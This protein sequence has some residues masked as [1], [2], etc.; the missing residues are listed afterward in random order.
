[1]CHEADK[2]YYVPGEDG[3]R[4]RQLPCEAGKYTAVR[5][6]A[7]CKECEAGR[8]TQPES[9]ASE[10]VAAS[11]GHY[12]KDDDRTAATNAH[13]LLTELFATFSHLPASLVLVNV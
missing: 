1:M 4:D 2:G 12:V 6:A 13:E 7:Q 11:P 3:Q 9:G 5:G 10:C 8:F